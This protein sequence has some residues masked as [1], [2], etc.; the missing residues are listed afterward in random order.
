[1]KNKFPEY[2][3]LSNNEIVSAILYIV[4]LLLFFSLLESKLDI[5]V[6]E[7]LLS[8]ILSTIVISVLRLI[9]IPKYRFLSY[10]IVNTIILILIRY[11]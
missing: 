6:F 4:N 8:L 11:C 1:M 9:S 5:Q 2:L 3:S 10:A 7:I